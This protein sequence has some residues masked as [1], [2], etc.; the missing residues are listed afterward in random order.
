[1]ETIPAKIVVLTQDS[2]YYDPNDFIVEEPERQKMIPITVSRE[3]ILK[4]IREKEKREEEDR[5][6]KEDEMDTERGN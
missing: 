1:M 2:E 3:R 4:E 5:R 6:N